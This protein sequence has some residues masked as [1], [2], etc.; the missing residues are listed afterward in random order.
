[1]HDLTLHLV[2]DSALCGARGVGAVV[3]AAVR[4]GATCVQLREK[5]LDTRPFVERARA[6]KALLAPLRIP[7]LIND[8]LDVALAC[9]ADG[10]HVGQSDMAPDDVR[11]L[12][13][14]AMIGLS[15]ESVAQ[16]EAAEHAPVDYYGISPVF[17][18]STKTDAAPP[19]GLSGL[20]A[21]RALTT[22]PLIAI[23]GIGFDN[24]AAVMAAGANGLAVVSLICAAPDPAQ[25]ARRLRL[26][27]RTKN[28]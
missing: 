10:L 16:L 22:R 28:P 3:E 7:L 26:A 11:R 8:R 19:L 15:I 1:M 18:T 20:R 17:A 23:G 12:M 6:L 5:S 27:M 13:P 4:G 9:G 14:Q 25:A 21:I 2:T 24:A